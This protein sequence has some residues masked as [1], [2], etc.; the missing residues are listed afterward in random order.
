MWILESLICVFGSLGYRISGKLGLLYLCDIGATVSQ[1]DPATVSL[2]DW[3]IGSL[4][5]W[6]TVNL[7]DWAI[8]TLGTEFNQEEKRW[9]NQNLG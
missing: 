7:G 6:A 3:A 9:L 8:V 1:G 5:D 2:G 4:R